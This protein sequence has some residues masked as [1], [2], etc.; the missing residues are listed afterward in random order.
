MRLL[1]QLTKYCIGKPFR[2]TVRE[3][4]DHT[5]KEAYKMKESQYL[6]D[7]EKILTDLKKMSVFEPLK[8]EDLKFFLKMSKLRMYKSGETITTPL[9][10]R[11]WC[12]QF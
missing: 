7:N 6:E 5:T 12:F 8:Q 10:R 4:K 1:S 3:T 9:P 11:F 2:D